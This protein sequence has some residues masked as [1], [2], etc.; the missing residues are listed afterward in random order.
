MSRSPADPVET[1]SAR[2]EAARQFLE[3]VGSGRI[4]E[5]YRKYVA[6]DGKHHNPFFAAGFPAQQAAMQANFLQFPD[7]RLTI[8]DVIG[9]GE[10]V[11][12]H[13]HVVMRPDEAGV[14]T[15]HLFR[16]QAGK[17]MEMWDIAQA[18]PSDSPN[19]DGMF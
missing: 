12:V 6:M 18:L 13:S 17:I 11:A 5:A 19:Q 4:D 10:M 9:E 1:T 16:F 3:L 8:Q 2:K 7:M 15:V 14:A